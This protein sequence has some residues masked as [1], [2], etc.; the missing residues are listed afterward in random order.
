MIVTIIWLWICEWTVDLISLCIIAF[1]IV[2]MSAR[3]Y[4]RHL[5]TR[6]QNLHGNIISPRSEVC[7]HKTNLTN[8]LF[9]WSACTIPEKWAVMHLFVRAI[10]FASLDHFNISFSN[11]SDSV[12]FVS[13]CILLLQYI[14]F[15][16]QMFNFHL[17]RMHGYLTHH[18][19]WPPS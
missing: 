19:C 7:A 18:L 16:M 12:V 17:A 11:S 3:L 14:M 13:S 6:E 9:Y 4:L 5:L 2:I 10:H 8:Q 15:I 1:F